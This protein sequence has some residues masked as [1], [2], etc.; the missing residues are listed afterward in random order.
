MAEHQRHIGHFQHIAHHQLA[1]MGQI[2][3]QPPGLHLGHHLAAK[4]GQPGT[5]IA[6]Q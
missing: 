4:F 6:M 5:G 1:G 2:E 3:D